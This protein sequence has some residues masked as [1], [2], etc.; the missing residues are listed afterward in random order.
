MKTEVIHHIADEKA[1]GKKYI[2]AYPLKTGGMSVTRLWQSKHHLTVATVMHATKEEL[3]ETVFSV[4]CVQKLYL[5]PCESYERLRANI[6]PTL[7]T[8]LIRSVMTYACSA[9]N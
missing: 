6:K 3:W 7:H 4:G 2:V 5:E 9:G 1:Y 8:A